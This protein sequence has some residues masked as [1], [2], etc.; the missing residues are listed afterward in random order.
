[1]RTRTQTWGRTPQGRPVLT[2][3]GTGV[4]HTPIQRGLLGAPSIGPNTVANQTPRNPAT[5]A[6]VAPIGSQGPSGG[7]AGLLNGGR[8]QLTYGQNY[9]PYKPTQGEGATFKYSPGTDSTAPGFAG[10][11]RAQTDYTSD[12]SDAPVW[13]NPYGAAINVGYG[14]GEV[15]PRLAQ[16][17]GYAPQKG[18]GTVVPGY[19]RYQRYNEETG[20]FEDVGV[21]ELNLGEL[22]EAG[23]KFVENFKL[24]NPAG[25]LKALMGLV[26]NAEGLTAADKQAIEKSARD[27]IGDA[28]DKIGVGPMSLGIGSTLLNPRYIETPWGTPFNAGGGGIIGLGGAASYKN[29]LNIWNKQQAGEEGYEFFEPGTISAGNQFGTVTTPLA[30][31]PAP[32]GTGEV[33]SGNTDLA[34]QQNPHLDI[35][36]DGQLTTTELRS[37]AQAEAAEKA[38]VQARNV[39]G[40]AQSADAARRASMEADRVRAEQ[41]R[42]AAANAKAAA[43]AQAAA[44]QQANRRAAQ[45]AAAAQEAERVARAQRIANET[46]REQTVGGGGPVTDSSGKP[47]TSVNSRTGQ[48]EIVTDR[49]ITVQPERDNDDSGGGGGGGGGTVICTALMNTGHISKAERDETFKDTVK[50][51]GKRTVRGYQKWAK[52]Q[53]W[54]VERSAIMQQIWLPM[55]KA[56]RQDIRYRLD[57]SNETTIGGIAMRY[58]FEKISVFLGRVF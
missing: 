40:E 22:S 10:G 4:A 55:Y 17:A 53:A 30:I 21:Q 27:Q 5:G 18:I 32:F 50:L 28:F 14:P 31:S 41:Q 6:P 2:D 12:Q 47:V 24:N 19:A 49:M 56:W 51:L 1:M 33:I 57:K 54:L 15:D 7:G 38:A 45:E 42:L 36:G 8:G 52:S 35:N 26:G 29:L 11:S 34:M 9:Q 37:Y 58:T 39:A 23:K 44:Q 13:H 25:S 48:K 16:A 46:G 43:A 3:L 20:Q